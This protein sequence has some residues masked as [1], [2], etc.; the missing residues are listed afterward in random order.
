[1]PSFWISHTMSFCEHITMISLRNM[2]AQRVFRHRGRSG[3]IQCGR[4]ALGSIDDGR[5]CFREYQ[6]AVGRCERCWVTVA[7]FRSMSFVLRWPVRRFRCTF[8]PVRAAALAPSP[9]QGR[10]SARLSLARVALC[11]PGSICDMLSAK[12]VAFVAPFVAALALSSAR[13][14]RTAD[15]G[16]VARTNAIQMYVELPVGR[17]RK[18]EG[19]L[20]DAISDFEARKAVNGDAVMN[21]WFPPTLASY[22]L[23]SG[24]ITFNSS[25]NWLIIGKALSIIRSCV[26]RDSAQQM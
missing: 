6:H 19:V 2:S 20:L 9:L 18:C 26:S 23:C 21:V 24:G 11:V 14:W 25:C 8:P 13:R 22:L 15:D 5:R 12:R 16:P 17:D 1:M 3:S 7:F 10:S 4:V